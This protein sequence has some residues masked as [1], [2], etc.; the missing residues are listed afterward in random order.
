M[1]SPLASPALVRRTRRRR[2]SP[3]GRHSLFLGHFGISGAHASGGNV[4]LNGRVRATVE[5]P[6]QNDNEG[7]GSSVLA[8][9]T[10]AS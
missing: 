2:S 5:Y 10:A 6:S 1:A 7:V 8:C 9:E 3:R 4:G